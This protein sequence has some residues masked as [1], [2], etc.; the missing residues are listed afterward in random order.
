LWQ[1]SALLL[2]TKTN[3]NSVPLLEFISILVFTDLSTGRKFSDL[4]LIPAHLCLLNAR[5]HSA[6]RQTLYYRDWSPYFI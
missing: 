1:I 2:T 4:L 3:N 6:Y 5:Q